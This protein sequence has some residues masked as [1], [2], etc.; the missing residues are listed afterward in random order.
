MSL[1][2]LSKWCTSLKPKATR[3][4]I[5]SVYGLDDDVLSDGLSPGL[6]AVPYLEFPGLTRLVIV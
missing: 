1:G 3:R 6:V 2:L 4:A 5:A